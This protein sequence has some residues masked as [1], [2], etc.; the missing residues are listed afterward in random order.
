MSRPLA[1]ITGASSGFGERF[2]H[3]FTEEG[4]DVI[5]VARR[6]ERL[7]RL[8]EKLG[9]R[10]ANALVLPAD[11]SQPGA[12]QQL[13]DELARRE[14]RISALVN[15]AGLGSVA[16]FGQTD[17]QRIEQQIAVN[18]TALTMLTRLLW[19]QLAGSEDAII[20]NVSSTASFQPLPGFA[21]YAATKAYVRAL[22]E[23]LWREAKGSGIRV[24]T[25]APGPANTEFFE[26]AGSYSAALGQRVTAQQ[27]VDLTFAELAHG[28]PRPTAVVGAFNRIQSALVRFLPTRLVMAVVERQISRP[29]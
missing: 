9:T 13:V 14:L 2:A 3:R 27:V 15:N 7:E 20:V 24:L 21:V 16:A 29:R 11:L 6:A 5:L 23:A 4:Y 22:T 19:P 12:A 25:V 10:G 26:L 1:L 17:P 28:A 18:V 8:A